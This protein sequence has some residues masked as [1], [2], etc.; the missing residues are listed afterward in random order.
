MPFITPTIQSL[1]TLNRDNVTALLRSGPLIPN[2]V[3]RVISDSN[4]G[5]AYLTLLY[6]NWLSKQLLPDTAEDDWLLR[7]ANIWNVPIASSTFA[8]GTILVTGMAGIPIPLGA[9]LTATFNTATGGPTTAIF[10]V[11][12]L[13]TVGA[14][15]TAVPVVALTAG[16]T[17]LAIGSAL[18]FS[19]GIAGVSGSPTLSTFTDGI[20]GDTEDQIRANVLRRIQL[21]PMGGDADDYVSWVMALPGV[22]RAWCSPQELGVGTVTLR[23]MMDEAQAANGGIPTLD[24]VN[25]VQ[26]AIDAVRPVTVKDFFVVAPMPWAINFGINNLEPYNAST[27]ENINTSVTAMLLDKAAPA[28]ALR[29]VW[30]AATTIY[31]NWVSDAITQ[32]AG[33][34]SFDL[35]MT[36]AVPPNNGS[37]AVLGSITLGG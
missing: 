11:Q 18:T 23:F 25:A 27:I 35:V 7:F 22:T 2:S 5:L 24:Q 29:G 1:R 32:T 9:Q 19:I 28:G 14:V 12:S 8:A 34:E 4:A 16:E 13:T 10:Q 15:P 21:P 30:Q 31:A 37:L 26:V 20:D 3:L 33:V 36:D 6:L 17:G